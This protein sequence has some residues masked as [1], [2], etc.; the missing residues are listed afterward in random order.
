MKVL[1]VDD[2]E[3]IREAISTW[4]KG[5]DI[6]IVGKAVN[7]QE[8][9]EMVRQRKPDLVTLDITMP[10]MDGLT[11]LEQIIKINPRVK[12]IIVS[13][14][15]A[16]E[17]ALKAIKMG[18]VSYLVKPFTQAELREVFDEVREDS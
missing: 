12:V 18:A 5:S 14:L 13:A 9:V 17:T 7:G 10:E 16:K 1:I 15:A 11:A 3:I 4:I 8:A 6:E 2:S